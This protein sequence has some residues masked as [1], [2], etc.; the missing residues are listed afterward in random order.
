MIEIPGDYLEGGGQILRT[1]L[2]LSAVTGKPMHV[3]NIRAKRPKPGLKAQHFH[4]FKAVAEITDAQYKGL[5]I[6][7]REIEFIPKTLKSKFLSI[8]VGTAGSIGLLLQSL[9]L[10]ACFCPQGLHLKIRGGTCGKGQIP[11]EYYDGVILPLLKKIGVSIKLNLLRRGYYP[12]GGGE[13]GISVS[14]I[15][16]FSPLVLVEQGKILKIRGLSHAAKYLE[17]A[18]V[19]ERQA[20][21]VEEILKRLNVPIEIEVEYADTLSPGSGIVL[22]VE[23]ETGALFGADALGER[24]K[25]AE[26]VGEEVA[27]KLIKEIESNAPVDKHLADNLV[28]W[29][30]FCGGEVRVSEITLHTQTN[31]WVCEL[32]LGKIFAVKD[33]IIKRI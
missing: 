4:A 32:F 29:L 16:N 14:K 2:A 23:T 9:L 3:Y 31:I 5:E 15:Q 20:Q 7:S 10:P 26:R 24:S 21:K 12:K 33:N 27:I 8:D 13:I 17:K 25:P 11:I 30:A 6:G 28:P 18:K 19:A 1:A 22:W